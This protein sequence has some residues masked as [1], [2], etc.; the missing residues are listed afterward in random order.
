MFFFVFF[1]SITLPIHNL[2]MPRNAWTADSSDSDSSESSSESSSDSSSSAKPNSS[3]GLASALFGEDDGSK[4]DYICDVGVSES[5][6]HS[7]DQSRD[8]SNQSGIRSSTLYGSRHGTRDCDLFSSDRS[9]SPKR[10][11][12]LPD[13]PTEPEDDLPQDKPAA[14][15]PQYS[16]PRPETSVP[17]VFHKSVLWWAKSLYDIIGA[18]V[19]WSTPTRPMSHRSFYSGQM[20]EV[21]TQVLFPM[22]VHTLSGCDSK[23]AC[24]DFCSANYRLHC[25]HFYSS[26][27]DQAARE[28]PCAMHHSQICYE[29][30]GV[31]LDCWSGG[32]PCQAWTI[33]RQKNANTK[34]TGPTGE[35][36]HWST[37]FVDWFVA[38][39]A[40]QTKGG[41]Y[42]NVAGFFHKPAINRTTLELLKGH[43]TP[44]DLFVSMLQDRN[45]HVVVIKLN[46]T[47]FSEVP[48][49]RRRTHLFYQSLWQ[50]Y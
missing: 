39:D 27:A 26:L 15:M 38:L 14:S 16:R 48:R 2:A 17:P 1:L 33:A 49:D 35:H 31:E 32:S 10:V 46:A 45:Y 4:S 11:A 8:T 43:S 29:E 23:V 40:N 47:I 22:W 25:D 34:R 30:G 12:E 28:G 5:L 18:L 7:N 6:F 42:E 9:R 3:S 37:T 41:W 19:P 24:R 36:P 13:P 44:G 50:I 21:Q 20:G